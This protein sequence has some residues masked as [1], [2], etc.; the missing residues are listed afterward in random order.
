MLG[1]LIDTP[2][3][4]YG[5]GASSPARS[6]FNRWVSDREN[7]KK[8]CFRAKH[9]R[10]KIDRVLNHHRPKFDLGPAKR[11]DFNWNE[12]SRREI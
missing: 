9:I 5:G 6:A 3:G 2:G 1:G 12:N 4:S 11:R 7:L 10:L 8:M